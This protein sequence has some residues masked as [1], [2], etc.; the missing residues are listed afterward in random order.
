M[1]TIGGAKATLV[2][3]IDSLTSSA[4]AKDTIY[5]AK[6]LKE[7]S[8]LNN[9]TF[10][11][12]WAATTAYALDDVVTNGGNTYIC[13]AAH[14][15]GASFSVGSNWSLMASAGTDGTTVGTGTAGQVL[16]TNAAGTGIEWGAGSTFSADDAIL[17]F[18]TGGA[19]SSGVSQ[20]TAGLSNFQSAVSQ[21]SG[22]NKYY[23]DS[24][25]TIS[26]N[27]DAGDTSGARTLLVVNGTLTINSGV[28]LSWDGAG[29]PAGTNGNFNCKTGFQHGGSGSQGGGGV[30]GAA[31]EAGRNDSF[32]RYT[33]TLNNQSWKDC[34]GQMSSVGLAKDLINPMNVENW[35]GYGSGGHYETDCAGTTTNYG[36]GCLVII[37]RKIVNNGYIDVSGRD[38]WSNSGDVSCS[39]GASG[40][41]GGM[42]ALYA[43]D[44]TSNFGISNTNLRADGGGWSNGSN[45]TYGSG[46]GGAGLIIGGIY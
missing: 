34:K 8:S 30:G 23:A 43:F 29:A 45:S 40:G 14:T 37:A 38:A 33:G 44:K 21:P 35:M 27:W 6:A 46:P 19:N 3:K 20:I 31:P 4:T 11:G 24:D 12:A 39:D 25:V 15:S 13:I 18:K 32:Y 42:L 5:L 1:A 28:T 17:R 16:K 2:N 26:G 22:L 7:N 41:G 10:Q 9:F 36:G